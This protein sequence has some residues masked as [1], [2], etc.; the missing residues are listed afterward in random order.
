MV[1]LYSQ[2]G[3][4]INLSQW[5]DIM[6]PA[7]VQMSLPTFTRAFANCSHEIWYWLIMFL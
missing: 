2:L 6:G 3:P 5:H 4:N 7:M 1:N